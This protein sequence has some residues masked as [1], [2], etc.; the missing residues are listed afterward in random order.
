MRQSQESLLV[1]MQ[2]NSEQFAVARY[3]P[4]WGRRREQLLFGFPLA[5]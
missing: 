2:K 4:S 5:M 3:F 1:L